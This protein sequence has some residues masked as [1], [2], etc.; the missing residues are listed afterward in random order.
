MSVN[1]NLYPPQV[2]T[3]IPAFIKTEPCV[4]KFSLSS[5]N[6]KSSISD[7]VQ[8]IIVNQE[9]NTSTLSTAY[10][11]EVLLTRMY[12]DEDD[13]YYIVLYPEV[14]KDSAFN[15]DVNYKVQLRFMQSTM[16]TDEEL[17]S[18]IKYNP[19]YGGVY[20]SDFPTSSWIQKNL[21]AFSE[22]STVCLL[23]PIPAVSLRLKNFTNTNSAMIFTQEVV[24]VL[25]GI[26]FSEETTE[27]LRSYRIKLFINSTEELIEDS[28]D[29]IANQ[30]TSI[31]EINYVLR[32]TLNDSLTYRLEVE[33]TT[34][35]DYCQVESFVFTILKSGLDPLD[36]TIQATPQQEL[37]RMEIEIKSKNGKEYLDGL[38]IRRSS[39]EN[40]F[41]TWE[42]IHLTKIENGKPLDLIWYDYTVKSGVFYKYCAQRVN[43]YGDRGPVIQINSPVIVTFE[44]ILLTTKDL[45]I[46]I[47]FDPT[48]NSFAHTVLESKL[49]PLGSKYPF[50]RRNGNVNYRQFSLS[51]TISSLWDE[52]GY[53]ISR[54]KLY[55]QSSEDYFN[56]AFE[57]EIPT[58]YDYIYERE[59]REEVI[60]FLMDGKVKLFRST[61]EGNI[62]VRLMGVSF[63]PNETL[64]RLIYNFSAT[65][66]E[67][68]ECS[69]DNYDKYEIQAKG[70]IGEITR[71]FAK[72]AQYSGNVKSGDAL[73]QMVIDNRENTINSVLTP[74]S[75][76]WIRI[77][78][79]S[80][81]EDL[82]NGLYGHRVVINGTEYKI[83]S[84]LPLEL[85][86]N[87][88][89]IYDVTFL[90]EGE[91]QIDYEV[92]IKES[93]NMHRPTE[94]S[95]SKN[96]G[97]INGI[98]YPNVSI[99]DLIQ[100]KYNI[101]N[102]TDYQK[103]MSINSLDIEAK[104]GTTIYLQDSNNS[105]YNEFIIGETEFLSFYDPDAVILDL[106]FGGSDGEPIEAIIN[107]TYE[108]VKGVYLV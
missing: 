35:N 86:G 101:D 70:E 90:S 60:K 16:D 74:L 18:H 65:A 99:V 89:E 40:D 94:L 64:G 77:E 6:G 56:Y 92:L 78:Y 106:K 4:L 62:L 104:E 63:E 31:N 107:Y 14:L 44:D 54:E 82:G 51:G 76:N 53:F 68:D 97:Q 100:N 55:G 27:R 13:T 20:I 67:V 29:I 30:Y 88:I 17:N 21:D 3:W 34:T 93:A 95:Y 9:T 103:L 79:N 7:W 19:T 59:F 73:S 12:K 41:K 36:A 81:A 28:G 23:R 61:P 72:I 32:T 37:G 46:N 24:D 33:Y 11:A 66:Y 47:K 80:A 102:A 10:P 22:W 91:V 25:G 69:I 5:F 26:I 87:E 38:I 48:I 15:T 75:Y 50:I 8:V 58:Y 39:S 85:D 45:Q 98:F 42:D 108:K 84:G 83:L 57:N 52:D 96:I 43:S 71:T 105:E 2:D 1:N 49:D